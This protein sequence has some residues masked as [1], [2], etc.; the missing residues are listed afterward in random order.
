MSQVQAKT[1]FE[2]L[3]REVKGEFSSGQLR[4]LQRRVKEWKAKHGAAKEVFF[5]QVH[6]PGRL[7]ASDFTSCNRPGVTIGRQCRCLGDVPT[8]G[9]Q[10]AKIMI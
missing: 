8:V 4:T 7:A 3:L 2:W 1:L 6:H 10:S 9:Q 5:A